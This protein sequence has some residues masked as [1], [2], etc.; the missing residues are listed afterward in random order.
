MK[1]LLILFSL[2]ILTIT[3]CKK[4]DNLNVPLTGLGGDTWVKTPIDKWLYDSVTVPTNIEIKYKWDQSE[5]DMQ[6]TL[7]PPLESQVVPA[8][9]S[10]LRLWIDTYNAEAGTVMFMKKYAPKQIVLSGSPAINSDGT[11]VQG[12][13][14]G[15]LKILLFSIN[16]FNP[17]DSSA[18]SDMAHLIHH[19]FT[20]ILN[21][22]KAYPIEY[23]SVTPSG[24]TGG[25]TVAQENPLSL[26][27][28]S[29]YARKE[30][31]EDIAE[32]VSWMLVLGKAR[33]EK[34][35]ADFLASSTPETLAQ[36]QDGVNKL[37]KKEL[38]IVQYFKDSYS[39]DFYSL[40]TRV[41]AAIQQLIH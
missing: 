32:M 27:F 16:T 28:I 34:L 15:G 18:V 10:V 17:K 4:K 6:Y 9:Q 30:P 26:G 33:Y 7:V 25:W 24:Y 19:E 3:G 39:L 22:K 35:L 5:F 36:N 23:K 38:L 29:N 21:Q 11:S 1:K 37:R 40:Q 31:G 12:L 20:H 13:A 41:Q 8:A 14:E 2:G